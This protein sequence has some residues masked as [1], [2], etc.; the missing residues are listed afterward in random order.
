MI[1]PAVWAATCDELDAAGWGSYERAAIP[2]DWRTRRPNDPRHDIGKKTG[3]MRGATGH[4]GGGR[5][6][7]STAVRRELLYAEMRERMARR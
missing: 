1:H 2:A 7:M 3:P 4:Q 6:R 5:R